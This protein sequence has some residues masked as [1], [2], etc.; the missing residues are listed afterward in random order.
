MYAACVERRVSVPI[1]KGVSAPFLERSGDGL[2]I[3]GNVYGLLVEG[4]NHDSD[5]K[6]R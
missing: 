5:G 1:D 4:R 3:G 6:L 2:L